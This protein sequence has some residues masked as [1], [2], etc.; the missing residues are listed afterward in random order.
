MRDKTAAFHYGLCAKWCH[1]SRNRATCEA[2]GKMKVVEIQRAAI[3]GLTGAGF[4][5]GGH[6]EHKQRTGRARPKWP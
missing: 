1:K 2:T 6:S 5:C 3:E 4:Q